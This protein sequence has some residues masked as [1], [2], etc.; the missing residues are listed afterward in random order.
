M[1]DFGGRSAEVVEA[2]APIVQRTA[3]RIEAGED[4]AAVAGAAFHRMP[5]D[6]KYTLA[7]LEFEACV[8]GELR[9]R[10]LRKE[11]SAEAT[12]PTNV[13]PL[14]AP[15]YVPGTKRVMKH[16]SWSEYNGGAR[17]G[18]KCEPCTRVREME[19][20][21]IREREQGMKRL[22]DSYRDSLRME[23]T[24]ELRQSTFA[25]RDGTLVTWGA[26]SRAHHEERVAIFR[27]NAEANLEG[28][29]RHMAAID[30]LESTGADC[31]DEAVGRVA[32]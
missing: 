17:H 31:L 27:A 2:L 5:R 19:H 4:L 13:V 30:T 28:A 3:D 15:D 29:A 22:L 11:R 24:E 1:S 25:L 10:T 32:A 8:R 21:F 7:R 16:G 26:A 12:V 23:W 6:L 9:G 20:K 18:C 14:S